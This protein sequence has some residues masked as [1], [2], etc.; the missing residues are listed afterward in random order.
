M[1]IDKWIDLKKVQDLVGGRQIVMLTIHGSHLYGTDTPESDVDYKGIFL[2]S[3]ED[4]LLQ[5]G[6]KQIHSTTGEKHEKNE[7]GD[8]DLDMYSLPEFIRLA[9]KGETMCIDMLHSD[10]PDHA[11]LDH[12]YVWD[13]IIKER[14]RFITTDM[15][16]FVGYARRQAAKYGLKGERLACL[17]EVYDLVQKIGKC[18]ESNPE[19]TLGFYELQHTFPV[20]KYCFFVT[21][22]GQQFYEVLGRKHQLTIPYNHFYKGVNKMWNEYG[23]RAR[24]AMDNKGI[25]WKAMHHAHRAVQQLLELYLYGRIGYPLVGRE[26]LLEIKRGERGFTEVME[27]LDIG[28]EHIKKLAAESLY[29]DKVDSKFWDQWLKNTLLKEV[30]E[31]EYIRG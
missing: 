12:S 8:V 30:V 5:N 22:E 19:K 6:P 25:D 17:K 9:K 18:P 20:N 28:I 11:L 14:K 27:E 21:H 13:E 2:P 31:R 4:L 1:A 26:S 24:L 23:E 29:P 15:K 10:D 7:K 16:A 3:L